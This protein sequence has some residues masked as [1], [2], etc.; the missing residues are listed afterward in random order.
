MVV[1]DCLKTSV[2][3]LSFCSCGSTRYAASVSTCSIMSLSL[4]RIA[5]RRCKKLD[6]KPKSVC[7]SF[8][9]RLVVPVHVKTT[10]RLPSAV[11]IIHS[12]LDA[13]GPKRTAAGQGRHEEGTEMPVK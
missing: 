11:R 8:P 5:R 3:P 10:H 12:D 4:Y 2:Q 9:E 13:M 1:A 6:S 7:L